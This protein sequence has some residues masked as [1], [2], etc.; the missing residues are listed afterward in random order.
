MACEKAWIERCPCGSWLSSANV[1]F[2]SHSARLAGSLEWHGPTCCCIEQQCVL[3]VWGE[4]LTI[5]K[6]QAKKCLPLVHV[7]HWVHTK[8]NKDLLLTP[9]IANKNT[10][11]VQTSNDRPV[12]KVSLLMFCNSPHAFIKSHMN[13]LFIYWASLCCLCQTIFAQRVLLVMLHR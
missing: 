2:P 8:E 12:T 10:F 5:S 7:D 11:L 6:V 4:K 13:C 9:Q 1:S 3:Y